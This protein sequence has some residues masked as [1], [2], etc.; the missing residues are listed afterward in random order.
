MHECSIDTTCAINRCVVDPTE[1]ITCTG[2]SKSTIGSSMETVPAD[3][4]DGQFSEEDEE[5]ETDT[6][7]RL[8][9]LGESFVALGKHNVLVRLLIWHVYK[10]TRV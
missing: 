3:F 9:P 6:W 8:F 1:I 4:I 5:A 10:Y 7:G 2:E